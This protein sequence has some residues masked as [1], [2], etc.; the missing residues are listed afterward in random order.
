MAMPIVMA[1][2]AEIHLLAGELDEAQA[3]I[4]RSNIQ[5]LPGPIHFAAAAHVELLRGRLASARGDYGRAVEIADTV[6]EWLR[7]LAVRPFLPA[8]LL[9]RGSALLGGGDPAQAEIAL[10]DA[11]S[12]AE[13]LGFGTVLWRIDGKLS[14][15]SV[16]GGDAARAAEFRDEARSVIG[17][18]V[19]SI[20]DP[21]LRASFLALPDV[22]AALSER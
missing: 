16:A 2:K 19:E 18:I 12:E 15:I 17:R 11:R 22:R 7:R 13:R 14:D 3:T 21:E 10:I 6:L 4:V 5:R 20:N 9:L 1:S 8:A